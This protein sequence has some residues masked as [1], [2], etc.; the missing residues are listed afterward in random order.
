MSPAAT[1]AT[2]LRDEVS[3]GKLSQH[4]A[5]Q[6]LR[7]GPDSPSSTRGRAIR[8]MDR[9]LG[10]ALGLPEV[11]ELQQRVDTQKALISGNLTLLGLDS[12][13]AMRL[14]KA[15]PGRFRTVDEFVG[16][17]MPALEIVSAMGRTAT[18]IQKVRLWVEAV[19]EATHL[20][21]THLTVVAKPGS[22]SKGLTAEDLPT[23]VLFLT[24]MADCEHMVAQATMAALFTV[25]EFDVQEHDLPGWGLYRG[26]ADQY[27]FNAESRCVDPAHYSYW[28]LDAVQVIA[29]L[30]VDQRSPRS[31]RSRQNSTESG[32]S[33]GR[34]GSL[35]QLSVNVP[36]I[37][38]GDEGQADSP[39]TLGRSK[40]KSFCHDAKS[41][42]AVDCLTPTSAEMQSTIERIQACSQEV[43]KAIR[44]LEQK[45]GKEGNQDIASNQDIAAIAREA[46]K[47]DGG[48][49]D[50][51]EIAALA[52]A[53]YEAS[54]QKKSSRVA[55]PSPT[56][57]SR[58]APPG[59]PR[60]GM[61]EDLE[62][63]KFGTNSESASEFG[64]ILAAA[65]SEQAQETKPDVADKPGQD[66]D[67]S[68]RPESS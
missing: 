26:V 15:W 33:R 55:P 23:L 17:V 42:P 38:E 16:L 44:E 51:G 5:H 54:H 68:M 61:G 6:Q 27:V 21:N 1:L 32:H 63:A 57:G 45:E 66:V 64:T 48:N 65:A 8:M 56:M 52:R 50:I 43:T 29:G 24:T 22:S 10:W 36:P 31:T 60:M 37:R 12:G 35:P 40:S 4:E 11:R 28:V 18:P 53:G 3:S 41:D 34:R 59:P 39:I 25:D 14:Q 58:A 20:I 46:Q 47:A 67:L 13:W 30:P 19:L 9:M 7:R 49:H 2:K 62:W